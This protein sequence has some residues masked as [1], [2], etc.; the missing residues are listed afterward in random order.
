MFMILPNNLNSNSQLLAALK[1]PSNTHLYHRDTLTLS[2]NSF[3]LLLPTLLDSHFLSNLLSIHLD[4]LRIS[5][6]NFTKSN[7]VILVN[8][9]FC[10][11]DTKT[12]NKPWH[13]HPKTAKSKK[14]DYRIVSKAGIVLAVKKRAKYRGKNTRYV[15]DIMLDLTGAYFVNLSLL[16]QL[17]VIHHLN[18][19]FQLKCH[20]LDVAIDDYSRELF[21]VGQMITAYLEDNNYGFE[22]IDD[23][24]LDLVD[25]RLTGTLGIGSRHSSFFV[26]IYTRH[27]YFVRWETE[28]KQNE[29][30]KLFNNLA[31]LADNK[32]SIQSVLKDVHTALLSA[33]IGQIDFRDNYRFTNRKHASRGKTEQLFFWKDFLDKVEQLLIK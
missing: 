15:Y 27:S 30:Q 10:G 12:I 5:S 6:I 22:V 26:R 25:K 31:T 29:A 23:N 18:D 32:S 20:R 4:Y 28:L 16:E 9:L 21:P 7:L 1:S 3:S 24:Y 17:K 33:A 13:P 11:L 8:H 14:Y 2:T 19:N